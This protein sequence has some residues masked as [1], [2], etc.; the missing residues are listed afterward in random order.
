MTLVVTV[1]K[2]IYINPSDTPL[3]LKISTALHG[4]TNLWKPHL[5][6]KWLAPLKDNLIRFVKGMA[7]SKTGLPLSWLQKFGVFK[8]ILLLWELKSNGMF[9][10][11]M[12]LCRIMKRLVKYQDDFSFSR[13][14]WF[15]WMNKRLAWGTCLIGIL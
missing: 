13:W 7:R 5:H 9:H 15:K 1:Q 2:C 8:H 6:N 11:R 4:V 3:Q 10:Q 12:D 14:Y